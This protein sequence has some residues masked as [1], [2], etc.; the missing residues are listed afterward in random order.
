M[1]KSAWQKYQVNVLADMPPDQSRHE[2]RPGSG[3]QMPKE[4]SDR[5]GMSLGRSPNPDPPRKVT[6]FQ[7]IAVIVVI[8]FIA[9]GAVFMPW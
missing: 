2:V 6:V 8:A 4:S 5:G 1:T 7:V 9:T 3:L